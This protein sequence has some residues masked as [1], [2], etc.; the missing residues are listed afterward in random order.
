VLRSPASKAVPFALYE[1]LLNVGLLEQIPAG[2]Q[3]GENAGLLTEVENLINRPNEDLLEPAVR[4]RFP[5]LLKA[6]CAMA[7][8]EPIAKLTEKMLANLQNPAPVVRET[9]VKTIRVFQEALASNRKEKL[10]MRIV[11]TLHTMAESESAP[12]VYGH[13]ADALQV[14][15]MEL[16]VHWRFEDSAGLLATLRRQSREESPIGHKQKLL[17]TKALHEFS[18]RGLE[19]ICSDLNAPI[20]DRQNGAHRILAELGEEAVGPLVEA[21]K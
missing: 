10:F 13:I 15:A 1:E 18:A 14:A 12:D 11:S 9:A 5:E 21:V 2:I 3:K 4:Q 8:D 6:L 17:A 19:V 20:K 7:L 16:L